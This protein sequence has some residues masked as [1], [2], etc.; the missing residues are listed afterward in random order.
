T[1]APAQKSP[2]AAIIAPA[3]V[4]ILVPAGTVF[5]AGLRIGLT[6]ASGLTAAE[7]FTGFENA[8]KTIKL[9]LTELPAGAF[10]D[11]E[12]AVKSDQSGSQAAAANA[13]KPQGI[14]TAAGPAYFTSEAAKDG[15]TAVRRYS[16]I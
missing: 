8:D 2:G 12:N 3:P 5:P 10:A 6:P 9:I 1:P 4:R 14:E 11:I 15:T 13:T 16:M 7:E